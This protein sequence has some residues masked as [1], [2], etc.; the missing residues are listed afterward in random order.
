MIRVIGAGNMGFFAARI[1]CMV[2]G[3]GADAFGARHRLALH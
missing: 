3:A 1:W 2:Y